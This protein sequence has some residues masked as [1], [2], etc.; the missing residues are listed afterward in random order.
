MMIKRVCEGKNYFRSIGMLMV[1]VLYASITVAQSSP[2]LINLNCL[3]TRSWIKLT[4]K[5][6]KTDSISKY[7][8]YWSAQAKKPLHEGA[9]VPALADRYYITPVLPGRNY[10]IWIEADNDRKNRKSITTTAY[11]S[12]LWKID[13]VESNHLSIPSSSAVPQGMKLFWQDEF[14]DAL[15]NR[16]K[17][18]TNYY[19]TIDFLYKTN[20]SALNHDT[21]PQPGII[22]T[23]SSIKLVVNDSIPQRD[24]SGQRRISSIQTYDW[25]THESYLDNSRGG[26]F[27]VRVRRS[28]TTG[29]TSGLNAAYWFDSPGPDLKYYLEKGQ[30]LNGVNGVRPHGQAFEI[31]VFEQ[32]DD[33]AASTFT[34]FTIHGKVADGGVFKGNLTTFNASLTGQTDWVT[35]GL[36][37]TPSGIKYYI[38]GILQKEWTDTAKN[39]APN[40]LMNVLIGNYYNQTKGVNSNAVL[41]VDY[42]RG[43]QWPLIN[44]NELPNAGFEYGTLKPW[45][46]IGKVTADAKRSGKAGLLLLPNQTISQCVFLDNNKKYQ[47]KY[48]SKGNGKLKTQVENLT[49][50]TGK[51]ESHIEQIAAPS[52]SFSCHVLHFITG[53]EYQNN[54]KTVKITF[55]N[56]GKAAI[57][58]DDLE[59]TKSQK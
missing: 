40:H 45:I 22:M 52:G 36:L 55:T 41:E 30:S 5:A 17:W 29:N 16:N 51:T 2:K 44:G 43:Y 10:H 8:I 32:D 50:V 11:T 27:E 49:Q 46:G 15:L 56:T 9:I 59:T 7:K 1:G 31:D 48:W 35:H 18:S 4:W 34:P 39:M 13:T 28:N 25:H 23:G 57:A 38:N 21:L 37:W 6:N 33:A 47:L 14:N 24:Y 53:D 3:G 42:I 20:L 58:L 12:T 26:Y 19:S 54:M